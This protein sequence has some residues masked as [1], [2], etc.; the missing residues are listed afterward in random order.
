MARF[1]VTRIDEL[2]RIPVGG[3]RPALAA[4]SAPARDRGIRRQRLH[5]RG[6]G[7]RG[8]RGARRARRRSGQPRGA[9]R[10][11]LRPRGLHASTARSRTRPPGRSS[12]SS[13]P[14]VKRSAVA[15][16]A[17]TTVLAV[18]GAARRGLQGLAV[19]VLLRGEAARRRG[20]PGRRRGAR[21]GGARRVSR[22]IR[23]CSTTSPATARSPAISTARPTCSCARSTPSRSALA[24]A[25]EDTDLDAIRDRPEVAARL[26]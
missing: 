1:E 6:G 8:R 3:A 25:R 26:G 23:P 7:R 13:D 22:T 11:P 19:G 18:G 14:A 17:G 21:R 4:D 24:W 2:D 5:L 16:E 9:L 15:R 20:R 12:S 10:R